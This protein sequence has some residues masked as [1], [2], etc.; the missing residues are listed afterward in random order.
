MVNVRKN[1][2]GFAFF[3][4]AIVAAKRNFWVSMQVLV[5]LTLLL[6]VVQF[7]FEHDIQPDKYKSLWDSIVWGFMNYLGDPGGFSPG[8]PV[9]LVGRIV[10]VLLSIVKIMIFA[11]P[12]GLV[13]NGFKEAM[14]KDKRDKELEL[15][16][17]VIENEFRTGCG[18]RLSMHLATLQSDNNA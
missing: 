15:Y 17:R 11:V 14:A 3:W 18:K 4:N 6:S 16:H 10:A 1:F 9:T 13:A 5:V 8:E 12:A 2:R 7:V